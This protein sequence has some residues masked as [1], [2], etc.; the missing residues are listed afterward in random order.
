MGSHTVGAIIIQAVKM[1]FQRQVKCWCRLERVRIVRTGRTECL[2][3]QEDEGIRKYKQEETLRDE[4][5]MMDLISW[6][7][8]KGFYL[9][10]HVQK[11]A[12][13]WVEQCQ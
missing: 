11:K 8:G 13:L 10:R 2:Q 5:A 6:E 4:E 1:I 7:V 3:H 12:F 9:C